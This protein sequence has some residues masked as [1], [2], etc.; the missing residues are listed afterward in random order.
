MQHTALAINW[1]CSRTIST[2]YTNAT[3]FGLWNAASRRTGRRPNGPHVHFSVISA[4]DPYDELKKL[5]K[6]K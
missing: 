1:R 2:I 3:I 6:K 5:N 4:D